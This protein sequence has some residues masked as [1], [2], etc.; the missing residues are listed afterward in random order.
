LG[1]KREKLVTEAIELGML[2]FLESEF[3]ETE[4]ISDLISEFKYYSANPAE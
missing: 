2:T 3:L 4:T 1:R